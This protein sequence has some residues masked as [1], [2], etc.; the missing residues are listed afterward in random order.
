M[1]GR[2]SDNRA[3]LAERMNVMT[4]VVGSPSFMGFGVAVSDIRVSL[5]NGRHFDRLQK[6]YEVGPFIAA[7]FAGSVSFGFWAISDL[8]DFLTP[9]DPRRRLGSRTRCPGMA[10][11]SEEGVR[12]FP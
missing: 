6:V 8:R 3:R 4:W 9:I 1:I 7:A 5:A 2:V 10:P 11:P 12:S